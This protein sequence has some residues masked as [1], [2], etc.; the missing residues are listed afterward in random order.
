MTNYHYANGYSILTYLECPVLLVQEYILIFLVLKYLKKI[1]TSSV[2]VAALY[3]AISSCF[4]LQIV[5]KVVLTFLAVSYP[6]NSMKASFNRKFPHMYTDNCWVI[7]RS[8]AGVHTDLCIEQDRSITGDS[9]SQERRYS[10]TDDLVY[11]CFHEPEWVIDVEWNK[12]WFSILDNTSYV[13]ILMKR[14]TRTRIF[15]LQRGYSRYGWIRRTC[16]S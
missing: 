9:S 11:I 6:L 4:A 7:L 14:R 1:N 2:L 3:F 8:I 16:C 10:V 5:P 15:R 12:H 13:R